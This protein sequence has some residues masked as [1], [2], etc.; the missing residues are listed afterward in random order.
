VSL[1][2]HLEKFE[3][4]PTSHTS[5]QRNL[6]LASTKAITKRDTNLPSP[7]D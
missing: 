2:K 4:E 1:K 3:D 5:S 7:Q 6:A